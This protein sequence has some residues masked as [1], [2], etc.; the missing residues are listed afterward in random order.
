VPVLDI[1]RLL[2]QIQQT[3]LASGIAAI[4]HIVGVQGRLKRR[5]LRLRRRDLRLLVR[6]VKRG[7]TIAARMP[8]IT[9]TSSS[10]PG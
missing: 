3:V 9:S 2:D 4:V 6:L 1:A 7:R 5:N 8:R 10:S